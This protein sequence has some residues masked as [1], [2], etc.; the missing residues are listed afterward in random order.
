MLVSVSLLLS[1][2][3]QQAAPLQTV[4]IAGREVALTQP[5]T[6]PPL[7][8]DEV[9]NWSGWGYA[10]GKRVF[11][12]LFGTPDDWSAILGAKPNADAVEIPVRF[13]IYR[14]EH[15]L[16]NEGGILWARRY[17]WTEADYEE[18]LKAILRFEKWVV[19]SSGGTAVLKPTIESYREPLQWNYSPATP[20]GVVSHIG[21]T[22]SVGPNGDKFDADDRVYRGPF[23]LNYLIFPSLDDG[24]LS[25]IPLRTGALEAVAVRTPEMLESD[26]IWRFLARAQQFATSSTASPSEDWQAVAKL[27]AEVNLSTASLADREKHRLKPLPSSPQL[28]SASW[29]STNYRA[30]VLTDPKAGSYLRVSEGGTVRHGGVAAPELPSRQ[31]PAYLT[32]RYRTSSPEPVSLRFDS[33]GGPVYFSLGKGSWP[34]TVGSK[35]ESGMQYGYAQGKGSWLVSGSDHATVLDVPA[36]GA[37]HDVIVPVAPDYKNFNI[38]PSANELHSDRPTLKAMEYD[39]ADF[40]LVDS[41]PDGTSATQSAKFTPSMTSSNPAEI[42]LALREWSKTQ[43]KSQVRA[44][45][46]LVEDSNDQVRINAMDV[47]AKAQVVEAVDA[48]LRNAF[49]INP[50]V[51]QVAIRD[52]ASFKEPAVLETLRRIIELGPTETSKCAAADAIYPINTP[53]ISAAIA[54]LAGARA[55]QTRFR[56]AECLADMTNPEAQAALLG[57]SQ[58]LNADV[59]LLVVHSLKLETEGAVARLQF[60]AVNDPSDPVRLEAGLQLSRAKD[61]D[62]QRDVLRMAKDE[63][64]WVRINLLKSL[65]ADYAAFPAVVKI[66]VDDDSPIVRAEAVN[67]IKDL[68]DRSQIDLEKIAKDPDPRVQAAYR[69]LSGK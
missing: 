5:T 40:K 54:G 49:S 4:S 33:A 67:H 9:A 53:E 65:S 24:Q 61:G 47:L 20:D 45:I 21:E 55:W 18:V 26:L 39:F 52:A 34:I 28:A 57:F 50:R 27:M 29:R 37:W 31:Q 19:W 43:D 12:K 64:S 42:C 7:P 25:N 35:A 6:V 56:A 8:E 41:L 2:L 11:P 63:S 16:E 38:G 36:D 22:M 60:M 30:A 17:G 13:L 23:T 48:M 69:T 32:F 51:A 44:I 62:Y 15:S 58:D 46:K 68:K 3:Q 1:A 59:R 10:S 66:L 14:H